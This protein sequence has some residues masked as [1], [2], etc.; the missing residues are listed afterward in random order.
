MSANSDEI[1]SLSDPGEIERADHNRADRAVI[2]LGNILAWLFPTLMMVIVIQV[3][4][5]NFGR[6]D[7]GPGNQ[8][9]LDDMQWWL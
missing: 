4:L 6:V 1:V 2:E 7:I 8:A 5:R 3:F 9:W